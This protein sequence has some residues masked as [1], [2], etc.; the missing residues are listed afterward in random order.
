MESGPNTVTHARAK[1][2]FQLAGSRKLRR[3]RQQCLST[4]L[5]CITK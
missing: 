1:V 2:I 3:G 4:L 5:T